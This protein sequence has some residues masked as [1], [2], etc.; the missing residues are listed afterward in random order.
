[1]RALIVGEGVIG[2]SIAYYLAARGADMTVIERSRLRCFRQIG[3]L[4]GDG[5]IRWQTSY[6][7]RA[8]SFHCIE[9]DGE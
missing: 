6:G 2:T 3:W 4:L 8:R 1:M 7:A 5:L 9:C